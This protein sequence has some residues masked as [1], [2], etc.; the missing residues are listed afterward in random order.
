MND[1]VLNYNISEY[2]DLFYKE[3]K[4]TKFAMY[5]TAKQAAYVIGDEYIHWDKVVGLSQVLFP[6]RNY[7]EEDLY[8]G[9][10]SIYSIGDFLTI[11]IPDVV[12]PVQYE[13]LKELLT[14]VLEYEKQQEVRI[15]DE[16]IDYY[17]NDAKER[18]GHV[19]EED[20]VIISEPVTFSIAGEKEETVI[21]R[22]HN[23]SN[24][25]DEEIPVGGL[26]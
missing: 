25:R 22:A 12:D 26:K 17:L 4:N 5:I 20:E 2:L 3:H 8:E 11:Y 10:I 16:G 23:L 18:I 9:A 24:M 21:G 15:I 6:S 13:C 19:V 7:N 14:D 1:R